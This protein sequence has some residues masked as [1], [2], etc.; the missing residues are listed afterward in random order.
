MRYLKLIVFFI[1][2]YVISLFCEKETDGFSV[3]RI[4]ATPPLPFSNHGNTLLTEEILKQ[5]FHY[6]ARGGQSFVFVSEDQKYVIKF[7]KNSPNAFVPL[8][9]YHTKKIN[10]LIRDIEGYLLAFE[11]I[12]E[13]SGLIFLKLDTEK[14]FDQT[15][16][17]VDKLGIQH[18]LPLQ[19][20]LFAIQKKGE[21]LY[22]YLKHVGNVQAVFDSLR[23]LMEIRRSHA[24]DDTDSHLAQNLGFI[25]GK[26]CF[27]DP[28]KFVNAPIQKAEYPEKFVTWVKINYPEVEL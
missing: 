14:A 2:F 12:P 23:A 13:E 10:K 21:P 28:G 9:K 1:L 15:V 20:T 17:L 5:P 8:K 25:D 22:S 11:R 26:P 18:Q 27:L 24:I 19:K 4:N 16:T 6:L 7:F 3:R